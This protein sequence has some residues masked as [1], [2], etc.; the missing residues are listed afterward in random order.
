MKCC[1][2]HI[3]LALDMYV[4]KYELPPEMKMLTEEEKLSTKCE[5]CQNKATYFVGN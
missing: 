4:D 3:E 1:E 2:D 5:F